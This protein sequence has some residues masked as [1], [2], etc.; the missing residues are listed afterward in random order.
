[1][2]ITTKKEFLYN[3]IANDFHLLLSDYDTQ[4]RLEVLIDNFAFKANINNNKILDVG[5]GLGFFT[6]RLMKHGGIVTACDLAPELVKKTKE[7]TQCNAVVA[8]AMEL[9]NFF[10]KESFDIVVSSECIEHTPNPEQS[11]KSMIGM[12]KPGGFLILSTPNK[13]WLP[14][15][16]LASILQLR[17]FNG[18]ENFIS[19]KTLRNTLS[20]E[21]ITI[22]NEYGL[23]LIPF[24][25]KLNKISRFMD[26]HM[27]Y[28]KSCM[29]N[30][31][32]LGQKKCEK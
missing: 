14:V 15:T 25:F 29:I 24:Q 16:K 10:P 9:E 1:M 6:E 8:D 23:H 28:L 20:N 13:L 3:E 5:C 2:R 11:I 12:L 4:R 27:Q 30:I 22:L 31:C 26:T 18:I 32:I 7:K 17:P 21:N 19:W